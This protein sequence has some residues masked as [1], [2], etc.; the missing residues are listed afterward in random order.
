MKL[1]KTLLI[2]TMFSFFYTL[3][4]AQD[5]ITRENGDEIQAQ[6]VNPDS[7]TDSKIINGNF[8]DT[9][10]P[11]RFNEEKKVG[12]K[13]AE[14][15]IIASAKYAHIKEFVEGMAAVKLKYKCGFIDKTG[16]QIIPCKYDYVKSF[17]GGLAVACIGEDVKV[18]G[19]EYYTLTNFSGEGKWGYIDLE[20]KEVIL[21]TY[22][23]AKSFINGKAEVNNGAKMVY[24][25]KK[26][27]EIIQN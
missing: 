16:A 27:E 22:I 17:S 24:I 8:G 25:N 19:N 12:L 6:L 4:N 3:I 2:F 26:G 13:D 10:T 23:F 18:K 1:L 14:G 15:N 11:V 21:F 9:I 5:I 20:G 7:V